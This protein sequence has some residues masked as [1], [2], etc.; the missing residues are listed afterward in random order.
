MVRQRVLAQQ[1]HLVAERLE[2]LAQAQQLV[3]EMARRQVR[4]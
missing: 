1:E 3:L 4:V 2:R